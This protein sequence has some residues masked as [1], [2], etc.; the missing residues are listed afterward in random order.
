MAVQIPVRTIKRQPDPAGRIGTMPADICV[1]RY[2]CFLV[3]IYLATN[4]TSTKNIKLKKI[5]A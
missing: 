5:L 4:I 1:L 2:L 3:N